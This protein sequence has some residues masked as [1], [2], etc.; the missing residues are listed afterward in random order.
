M[1]SKKSKTANLESKRPTLLLIGLIFALGV[2]LESFEWL[3]SDIRIQP[4]SALG[5]E[6][7]Y[8]PINEVMV[9]KPEPKRSSSA[10][11]QRVAKKGPVVVTPE[12]TPPV[13]PKPNPKPDP[14]P[15]PNP[16]IGFD[17][18]NELPDDGNDD[19]F[20]LVDATL[21][22]AAVEQKP[23]FIGGPQAMMKFIS[24]NVNYPSICR[25]NGVQG[26][27]FV[28]FII[29]EEGNV[30]NVELEK[31]KNK[32]LDK[33]AIRVIKKMP[34]WKPGKQRGKAVKVKYTIPVNYKLRN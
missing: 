1:E 24:K 14:N 4:I 33:E 13:T 34:K 27:V 6:D 12:P 2:T 22:F 21:P 29:D 23:E 31:G 5:D 11:R 26:R 17:I 3:K 9:V 7:L 28:S 16:K 10:S 15:N 19:D 18:D 32:H 8:E 30:T 25:D 20:V